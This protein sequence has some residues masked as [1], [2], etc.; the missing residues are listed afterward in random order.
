MF[1]SRKRLAQVAEFKLKS[2]FFS[3][4]APR[5]FLHMYARLFTVN[6][7]LDTKSFMDQIL[8]FFCLDDF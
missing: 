2:D 6:P 1:L 8:F 4:K 7:Y 3:L 5:Y